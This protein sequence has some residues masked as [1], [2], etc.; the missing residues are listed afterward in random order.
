MT[1]ESRHRRGGRRPP[2]R[3][4]LSRRHRNGLYLAGGL[5]LISG[6]GWLLAHDVLRGE[7]L[8][9]LGAPHPSEA[10][11]MRVHGAA[12]LGFLLAFGALLNGHI[13]HGWR[14]GHS[15][16]TGLALCLIAALLTVTGYGLYYVASDAL[17]PWISL[18]H[19]SIGL[20][21]GAVL[22]WHVAAARSRH[23]EAT[24]RASS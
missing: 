8:V 23:Q 22:F 11:W 2:H 6:V 24:E 15:R 21:S 9:A 5:L 7:A 18:F 12:L 19:W 16:R 13:L 17:R 14:Q 1:P 10:W 3:N 20:A 4:R